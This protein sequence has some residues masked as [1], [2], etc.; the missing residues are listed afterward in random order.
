MNYT[1]PHIYTTV[2]TVSVNLFFNPLRHF[3]LYFY[4][5]YILVIALAFRL[6]FGYKA[7][8]SRLRYLFSNY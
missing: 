4:A 7:K 8:V 6:R 1:L 2:L 5:G 3:L